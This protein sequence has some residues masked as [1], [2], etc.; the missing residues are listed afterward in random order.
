MFYLVESTILNFM[1]RCQNDQNSG[2]Q[3]FGLPACNERKRLERSKIL[4]R[5]TA[6]TKIDFK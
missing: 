4:S 2:L 1:G 3:E 6:K 5:L